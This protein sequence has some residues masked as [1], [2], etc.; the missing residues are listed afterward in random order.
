VHSK[1]FAI[2][3]MSRKEDIFTGLKKLLDKEAES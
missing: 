1:N 3:T 2:V